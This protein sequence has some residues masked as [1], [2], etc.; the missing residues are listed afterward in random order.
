MLEKNLDSVIR[1][2]RLNRDEL[3]QHVHRPVFKHVLYSAPEYDWSN[4]PSRNYQALQAVVDSLN[5][6]D[7]PYVKTLRQQLAKLPPGDERIR[8]DQKLSKTINKQ[9]TFTHRGLRDFARAA[10]EICIDLGIWAA[11]WYVVEV[12]KRAKIAADPYNNIMSAWQEKEKRYLLG[13]ISRIQVVPVS[14]KPEDVRLWS[15]AKVHSLVGCLIA[16]EA[17]AETHDETYSGLVFVTRR[18][19]VIALAEL[20]SRFP[21]IAQRF[22]TGCLLGSSNSFQRHTFLDI[23]RNIPKDSQLETLRDFKIGDKNLIISTSVAEEGIDIQACGSVIRFDP[24]SN[25]VSWAQSRGRARRKRSTFILMFEDGGVHHKLVQQW[26]DIETRM[27]A[28]Y[29]D[30]S[31]DLAPVP[32]WDEDDAE[33]EEYVV[34]STG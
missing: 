24:P 5:I 17:S 32:E 30:V 8:V 26:E 29:N 6:E 31:R 14:E 25:M 15:S 3:A 13:I 1:S 9:D 20:L 34:E 28:L 12:I 4:V 19:T 22:N 2:T 33:H 7:D 10:Q 27:T 16:E 18:D 11:D 21:E 23:T